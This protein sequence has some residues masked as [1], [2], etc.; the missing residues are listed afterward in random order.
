M[1]QEFELTLNQYKYVN[2]ENEKYIF[3]TNTKDTNK[4]S[5]K[6]DKFDT[7]LKGIVYGIRLGILKDTFT[8]E[9]IIDCI[10]TL[11]DKGILKDCFNK[12]T[13]NSIRASLYTQYTKDFIYILLIK[14]CDTKGKRTYQVSN[15]IRDKIINT[16]YKDIENIT[17]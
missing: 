3:D 13:S 6:S 2:K 11:I 14:S 15:D 17:L 16:N 5:I 8:I 9:N 4:I 1:I 7:T 12:L 10:K